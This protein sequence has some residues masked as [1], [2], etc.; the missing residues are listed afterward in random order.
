ME[1]DQI[2]LIT[3]LSILIGSIAGLSGMA[4]W[5][6]G[7][8]KLQAEAVRTVAEAEK[9]E[10]DTAKVIGE[11][12]A[13]LL[14]QLQDQVKAQNEQITNMTCQQSK[15]E[16][17]IKDLSNQV[18]HLTDVLEEKNALIS[19]LTTQVQ[20]MQQS[21]AAKDETITSQGRTIASQG[22]R[23]QELEEVQ[24]VL[25]QQ[26]LEL[27]QKPRSKRGGD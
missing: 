20:A 14:R 27:G 26:I 7:R 1:Q 19:E 17:E 15:S 21:Q 8:R 3:A 6:S 13:A 9:T 23:I 4:T 16:S 18:Q 12:W 22:Q 11:A 25:R 5:W 24:E 10:A 2:S